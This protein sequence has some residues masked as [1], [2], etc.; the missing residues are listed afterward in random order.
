MISKS[1]VTARTI[2]PLLSAQHRLD[3]ILSSY[4]DTLHSFILS[5]TQSS[6]SPTSP[7]VRYNPL[8]SSFLDA[9][10]TSRPSSIPRLAL[11]DQ[12][13]LCRPHLL[14]ITPSD[15]STWSTASTVS[16]TRL[17]GNDQVRLD[18]TTETI[19]PRRAL[20]SLDFTLSFPPITETK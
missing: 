18:T 1:K 10:T 13:I 14:S 5:T 20:I 16:T 6:P 4:C 17:S 7:N 3:S 12:G 19:H 11:T 2:V 8:V 9:R 15:D